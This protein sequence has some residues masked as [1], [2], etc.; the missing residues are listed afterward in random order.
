MQTL[1]AGSFL[2]FENA[3]NLEALKFTA[4]RL[5][6]HTANVAAAENFNALWLENL[7]NNLWDKA[8]YVTLDVERRSLR[9]IFLENFRERFR[10]LKP[11]VTPA[12]NS[13][14]EIL[15]SASTIGNSG[16][17]DNAPE[18]TEGG[19]SE[20]ATDE[21][22][23][24]VSLAVDADATES[25]EKRDEFLGFVKTDEPF[26]ATQEVAE[27]GRATTNA[28]ND[29]ERETVDATNATFSET[30]KLEN[31][32][33]AGREATNSE[34]DQVDAGR[35]ISAESENK[36]KSPP[37]TATAAGN[38]SQPVS[39]NKNGANK[40]ETKEPFEFGKCTVS[41]NLVLLPSSA[42]DN[43]RKA[44]VSASSH[45]LPPEIE[46]LE[47]SEGENLTEIADLVRDKLAR[48]KNTLP[49]KY[50]EQLRAS[51]TKSLKKPAPAKGLTSVAAPAKP[52][53]NQMTVEETSE[54]QS[55]QNS[56]GIETEQS[57][58]EIT[59]TKETVSALPTTS[60][61]VSQSAAAANNVQPSLF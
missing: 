60:A 47:I 61:V 6:E 31:K 39:A 27:T 4:R 14:A 59:A 21:S 3:A 33:A 23:F 24:S 43:K 35:E 29:A 46:F 49:A 37:A 19:K 2:N 52:D 5:A 51:K 16:L 18:I 38:N 32:S 15:S 10:E 50:I 12:Q 36:E 42:G 11:E 28:P 48:F 44:I 8:E 20:C 57:R 17:I 26:S 53:S 30:L 22:A 7:A 41:L 1:T 45:N 54:A 55:A 9:E 13:A 58:T 34:S 40:T 25:Q 56:S